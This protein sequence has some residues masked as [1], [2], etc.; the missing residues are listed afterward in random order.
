MY[1]TAG[2][3][4]LIFHFSTSTSLYPELFTYFAYNLLWASKSRAWP[5]FY[6]YKDS[7]TDYKAVNMANNALVVFIS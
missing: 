7:F 5:V 2:Q 3:R 1:S 6:Y 4:P